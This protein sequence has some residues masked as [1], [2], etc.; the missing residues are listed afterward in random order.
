MFHFEFKGQKNLMFQLEAVRLEESPLV[1][2]GSAFLL[3]LSLQL[4]EG[5]ASIYIREAICFM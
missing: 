3:Y 1:R 2:G 4:T 5:G